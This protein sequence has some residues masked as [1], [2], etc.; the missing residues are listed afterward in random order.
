MKTGIL[1]QQSGKENPTNLLPNGDFENW[2]AGTAVAPDGWTILSSGSSAVAREASIIKMGIYSAKIVLSGGTYIFL[3]QEIHATKGIA[4]WKGRT[5]TLGCWVYATVANITRIQI[6]D[7]V[8]NSYSSYHPGDSQ[9]HFLTV[10]HTVNSSATTVQIV[11]RL[12]DNGGGTAYFDGAMCV[13]GE[14]AFAFADKPLSADK[15]ST[16]QI[17]ITQ[18][19]SGYAHAI[20]ANAVSIQG[21]WE[22]TTGDGQ[23]T[24]FDPDLVPTQSSTGWVASPTTHANNDEVNFGTVKFVPGT[25][26][27]NYV[28]DKGT[29]SGIAE[30]LIG[31]TSLGTVDCYNASAVYNVVDVLTWTPTAPTS[32]TLRLKVTNKNGASNNYYLTCSRLEFIKTA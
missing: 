9:W 26:K 5:L 19:G 24:N 31:T 12:G 27:V 20:F 8:D 17:V 14:S 6:G 21:T 11:G 23:Q 25:Y 7:G 29:G 22:Q 16:T 10:N 4:Y 3:T 28:H 15:I 1:A 30:I 2:T 18:T 32:G 13:E